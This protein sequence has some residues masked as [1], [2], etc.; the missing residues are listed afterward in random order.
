MSDF[1][2][3][4]SVRKFISPNFTKA[5]EN[6]TITQGSVKMAKEKVSCLL[7]YKGNNP[8]GIVTE[9]DIIHKVIADGH[10]PKKVLLKTIMTPEIIYTDADESLFDARKHMENSGVRH[11]VVKEAGKIVGTISAQELLGSI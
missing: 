11:L 3:L 10:N 8:C 4:L 5:R 6:D 7:V 9:S 2:T 1:K